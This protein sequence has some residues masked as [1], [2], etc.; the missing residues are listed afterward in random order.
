MI[1][2]SRA[3]AAAICLLSASFARNAAADDA[4]SRCAEAFEKA[5]TDRA[6]GKYTAAIAEAA[7][8]SQLECNAAV[9]RECVKLHEA[10]KSEIPTLV[11]S[12][13]T[14]EGVE[15]AAVKVLVDGQPLL[16]QIDG[17]PVSLDP[18]VRT[19]RFE[20]E[21]FGAV[22]TTHTARVGDQNRLIEVVF[23]T[24]GG[25]K[26]QESSQAPLV[27]EPRKVP[28]AS[29]VLGGVG[30][31]AIGVGVY[32]RASGIADY[33]EL[34]SSCSPRCDEDEVDAVRTKFRLSWLP[35]GIGGAAVLGGVAVYLL[36][37]RESGPA[38]SVGATADGA[39]ARF[40]TRF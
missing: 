29:W 14:D 21:G 38:V 34:N 13:R 28:I 36:Q 11:F 7:T 25:K 22:E 15:I 5:Q 9:V 32:M 12:A 39:R 30:V 2:R 24:P 33:N 16:E 17:K 18:G 23:E 19:F 40:T 8:C 6:A 10:L 26:K 37:P 35:I 4:N 1:E 27:L 20:A 3:L 31:A